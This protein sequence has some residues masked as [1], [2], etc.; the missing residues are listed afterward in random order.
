MAVAEKEYIEREA[1]L[2]RMKVEVKPPFAVVRAMIA[3]DVVEAVRGMNISEFLEELKALFEKYGIKSI[4]PFCDCNDGYSHHIKILDDGTLSF[5]GMKINTPTADVVEVRH[6]D[7]KWG[8]Q[9]GQYGIWCTNCGAGW[10]DSE[11][12]E[13]IAHEHDYCPKCGA[14]MRKST[15]KPTVC[16]NCGN[17]MYFTDG[18]CHYCGAKVGGKGEG[19]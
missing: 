10:T 12:A 17:E 1:T 7:W 19:E 9:S 6:G 8:H 5:M 14:D 13:W 18:T 16:A 4:T 3:A 2:H 15:V 11:N